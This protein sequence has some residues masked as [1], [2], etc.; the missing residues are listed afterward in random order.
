MKVSSKQYAQ[1]LF[2]L[3]DRKNDDESKNV[4]EKFVAH[5]KKNGHLA[6]SREVIEQF[7]K[8]YNTTHNIVTATITTAFP[9]QNAQKDIVEKYIARE[10][11]ANSVVTTYYEDK[12][13][14]GGVIIRVDD[15]ILDA[16]IDGK[17]RLINNAL[18]LTT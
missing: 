8:I 13:I 12:N 16:S 7:E 1:T 18:R 10:Y 5:M 11:G 6:L 9:L 14:K 2:E 17:L 15:E 3:T 4:I